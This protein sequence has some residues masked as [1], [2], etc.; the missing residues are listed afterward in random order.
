MEATQTKSPQEMTTAELEALLKTKK[1]KE[2][3]EKEKAKQQY[4]RK[5]DET[6]NF[7]MSFAKGVHE[8]LQELKDICQLS[9]FSPKKLT[10]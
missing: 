9:P 10:S 1:E 7:V 8:Q 2:A 5:R 3:K 6:I 4:E